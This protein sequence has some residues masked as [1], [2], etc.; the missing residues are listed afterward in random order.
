[1]SGSFQNSPQNQS[2]LF[3]NRYQL[4]QL[5]GKGGSGQVFRALDTK[6]VP[7]RQVAVKILHPGYRRARSS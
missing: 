5:L 7:P 1:M 3:A 4:L 6:F 2:E